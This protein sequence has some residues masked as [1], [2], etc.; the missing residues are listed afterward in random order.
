MKTYE[1]RETFDSEAEI[2]AYSL[3]VRHPLERALNDGRYKWARV[4]EDDG[5]EFER[6]NREPLVSGAFS[7]TFKSGYRIKYP[8]TGSLP[9]LVQRSNRNGIEFVRSYTLA[10]LDAFYGW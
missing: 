4:Y 7:V 3:T 1:E 6:V 10:E 9:H 5:V 8:D 2:A